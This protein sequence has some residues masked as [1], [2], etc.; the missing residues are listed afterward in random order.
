MFVR[1][2]ESNVACMARVPEQ[3]TLATT[4]VDLMP[5]SDIEKFLFQFNRYDHALQ[6]L[7]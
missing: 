3:T 2:L 7:W 4:D 5:D 1:M 6:K